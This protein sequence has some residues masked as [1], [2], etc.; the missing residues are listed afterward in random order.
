MK[1]LFK[2]AKSLRS[3]IGANWELIGVGASHEE[4]QEKLS[5]S[6]QASSLARYLFEHLATDQASK[7]MFIEL[8]GM[9]AE[10]WRHKP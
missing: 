10:I 7:N 9:R 5:A 6:D 8:C 2:L 3:K 1:T 4:Y